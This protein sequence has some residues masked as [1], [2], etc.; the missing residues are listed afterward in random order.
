MRMNLL[1]HYAAAALTGLLARKEWPDANALAAEAWHVAK[2]MLDARAAGN[3][4][5]PADDPLE[6]LDVSLRIF[7]KLRGLGIVSVRDLT[8]TTPKQVLATGL[9]DE[10]LQEVRQALHRLGLH[11]A[12]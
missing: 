7:K 5:D 3:G 12:E 9:G 8:R 4:V 11:L 6:N 10:S 2:A 1:D